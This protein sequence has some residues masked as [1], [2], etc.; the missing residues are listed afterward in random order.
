[1]ELIAQIEIAWVEITY[2]VL[3]SPVNLR[4]NVLKN[5]VQNMVILQHN[6]YPI[7]NIFKQTVKLGDAF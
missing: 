5:V 1:M 3:W 6:E 4:Q 7:V 2:D